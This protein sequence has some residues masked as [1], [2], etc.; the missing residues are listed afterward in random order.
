MAAKKKT[1]TKETPSAPAAPGP[2]ESYDSLLTRAYANLPEKVL[3]T[4]RFEPPVPVM[5][6]EGNKT[7]I[8]N[9]KEISD[10]LRR[11]PQHILKFITK[12]LAVPGEVDGARAIL[13]SK[14]PFRMI[15]EKFTSY[16]NEFVL[17]HECKKPDTDIV[18]DLGVKQ[19]KCQVCG[20][21][22]PIRELKK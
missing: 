12:E 10:K 9:F 19:L 16:I 13:K 3:A 18:D 22:N 5:Q 8:T 4:E 1:E 6:I 2:V 20:A 11:Q 7:F 17:C 14:A 15:N 21:R